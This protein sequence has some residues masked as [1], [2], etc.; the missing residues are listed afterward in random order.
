M[1]FKGLDAMSLEH[2]WINP[3]TE[4]EARLGT[5]YGIHVL[6]DDTLGLPAQAH[7]RGGVVNHSTSL[8]PMRDQTASNLDQL[9]KRRGRRP[10]AST[11]PPAASG[12]SDSSSSTA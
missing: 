12:M 10:D 2:R 11:Y 1:R 9:K 6:R 4:D 8:H 7:Q 3:N 5:Q